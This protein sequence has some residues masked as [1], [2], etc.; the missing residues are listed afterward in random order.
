MSCP[1][2]ISISGAWLALISSVLLAY[3]GWRASV[4]LRDAY[5]VL[6][7]EDGRQSS[8]DIASTETNYAARA[9]AKSF[10][11]DASKWL[12]HLHKLL[13]VGL[14]VMLLAGVLEVWDAYCDV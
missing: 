14:L 8:N 13:L 3:P 2:W 7:E 10:E 11:N 1:G 4:L 9:L 5:R 6:Q 12:P